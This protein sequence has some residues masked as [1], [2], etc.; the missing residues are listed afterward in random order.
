M[1]LNQRSRRAVPSTLNTPTA[2]NVN[3]VSSV[4][5]EQAEQFLTQFIDAS[6]HNRNPLNLNDQDQKTGF[7]SN[8]ETVAVASQLK[9]IQRNLRGLPP[10]STSETPEAS[11]NN[12]EAN[13]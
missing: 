4:T 3:A 12:D 5:Q 13:R 2:V 8:S 10:L 9:R 7:S 11:N 6:E 1:S